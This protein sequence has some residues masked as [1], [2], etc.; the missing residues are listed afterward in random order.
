MASLI[1][2]SS[3]MARRGRLPQTNGLVKGGRDE[4]V[5]EPAEAGDL[6]VVPLEHI[7]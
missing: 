3:G 7:S 2:E 4:V 1:P 5:V 6:S